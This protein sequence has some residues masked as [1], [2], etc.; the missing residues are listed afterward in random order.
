MNI[1]VEEKLTELPEVPKALGEDGGHFCRYYDA[2]AD[3]IDDDMVASLKAQLDG[4]LIYAGLFAGVNSAFLALTLPEMSADP[5]DDTNALLLQLVTGSN[6][7]ITSMNDLPS[8]SF[9]PASGIFSINI[10]FSLS[11]TLA[12]LAAFLAV[13]GQQWLVYYRK[14]SGGGAEV[15]RWEQ[16][17]RYLG[18]KRWRLEAILDDIL[19]SLLQLG[20]VIF[21]IA[22]ALY[23]GTLNR[24][25]CYTTAIPMGLALAFIFFMAISATLDQWCPFKSPLSRTL[26]LIPPSVAQP[27]WHTIL[28]CLSWAFTGA[29]KAKMTIGKAAGP[30]IQSAGQAAAYVRPWALR[31]TSRAKSIAGNVYSGFGP[32]PSNLQFLQSTALHSALRHLVFS[33]GR[34]D[35]LLG[36]PHGLQPFLPVSNDKP[37][38]EK[39]IRDLQSAVYVINMAAH[40]S[41]AINHLST[42]Q[43]GLFLI[44][45]ILEPSGVRF[46]SFDRWSK[47]HAFLSVAQKPDPSRPFLPYLLA[48][49]VQSFT[50]IKPPSAPEKEQAEKPRLEYLSKNEE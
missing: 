39:A 13:L 5:V 45:L 28:A 17:R 8:A 41:L 50:K 11:L 9:A 16:L 6:H 23:L 46:G 37:N 2:L 14:R 29:V 43:L 10:L 22:F 32:E 26:Q 25:I 12:L 15:Q 3:E 38:F 24:W 19:P 34:A 4:I 18:A 42:T 21:C 48:C 27:A 40:Y 36:P 20:L 33:S 7:N 35:F 49:A 1:R 31:I 44:G 30:M 47:D